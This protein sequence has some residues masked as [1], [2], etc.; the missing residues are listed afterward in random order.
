LGARQV[1]QKDD[2]TEPPTAQR[3]TTSHGGV[4]HMNSRRKAAIAS[5][6]SAALRQTDCDP[7]LTAGR[8]GPELA[9]MG[10]GR[11]RSFRLASGDK[12]ELVMK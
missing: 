11:H 3:M 12:R 4:C 8:A 1:L 2:S 5:A 10:R 9:Q 6:K 7:D